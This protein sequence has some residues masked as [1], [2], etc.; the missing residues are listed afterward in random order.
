MPSLLNNGD[1]VLGGSDVFIS[2]L[3]GWRRKKAA[4]AS[5]K[6]LLALA[7]VASGFG[8][9]LQTER[10][11]VQFLARAHAWVAGQVLSWGHVRG[12]GWMYLSHI[13]VSLPLTPSSPL[14][15]KVNK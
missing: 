3:G 9:S 2:R 13:D 14:S 6:I 12:N 15:L 8:A 1:N 11:P 7:G 5:K 10:S 4:L